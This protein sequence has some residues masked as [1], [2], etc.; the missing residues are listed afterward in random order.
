MITSLHLSAR[1]QESLKS[2]AV[3]E[4]EGPA[5]PGTTSTLPHMTL[6][7]AMD[8][9]YLGYFVLKKTHLDWGPICLP[10]A[11]RAMTGTI[12]HW[13]HWPFI[14]RAKIAR[15]LAYAEVCARKAWNE[16]W[17]FA[18]GNWLGIFGAQTPS[19]FYKCAPFFRG[20]CPHVTH[21]EHW[22]DMTEKP[23]I[24]SPSPNSKRQTAS[25]C[26]GKCNFQHRENQDLAWWSSEFLSVC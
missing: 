17:M 23:S 14:I 6:F 18:K 21:V 7:K 8:F 9:Q 25:S 1:G 26:W 10:G 4:D 12:A 20:T 3:T 11:I 15:L 22:R 24:T 5:S 13:Q 2:S 16:T 19:V